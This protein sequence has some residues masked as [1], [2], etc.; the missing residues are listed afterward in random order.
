MLRVAGNKIVLR[1]STLKL[2]LE[3]VPRAYDSLGHS[4]WLLDIASVDE[5][6][7]HIKDGV[8]DIPIFKP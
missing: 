4:L 8:L 3:L 2:F 7:G 6:L 5:R 1:S